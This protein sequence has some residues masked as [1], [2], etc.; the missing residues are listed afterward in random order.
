M[1]LQE[2]K[3]SNSE[4]R[5]FIICCFGIARQFT[6]RHHFNYLNILIPTEFSL[7]EESHNMFY[8]DQILFS[9]E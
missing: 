3:S 9:T 5:S 1:K 8:S 4:I 2:Q 7:S 6:I